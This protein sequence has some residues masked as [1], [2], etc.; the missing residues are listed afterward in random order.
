MA[1]VAGATAAATAATEAAAGA[2]SIWLNTTSSGPTEGNCWQRCISGI[3]T[4]LVGQASGSALVFLV[5]CLV[6]STLF[7]CPFVLRDDVFSYLAACLRW[8]SY[9]Y[10]TCAAVG[11]FP[12]V[13]SG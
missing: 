5:N 12:G 11:N 6:V 9:R 2:N 8:R 1:S 3:D 4:L 7:S 13:S 10:Q